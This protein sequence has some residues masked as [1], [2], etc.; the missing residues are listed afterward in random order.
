MG[1]RGIREEQKNR[2]G[3]LDLEME[4]SE[5]PRVISFQ[6]F[7]E[8]SGVWPPRPGGLCF[9]APRWAPF[10]PTEALAESLRLF[11][12]FHGTFC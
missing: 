12:F 3:P 11:R 2:A 6:P 10:P 4:T 7:L 8:Q 9:G 5:A 1:E